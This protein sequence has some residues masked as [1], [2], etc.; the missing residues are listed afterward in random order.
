MGK[1]IGKVFRGVT[2]IFGGG[3]AKKMA[4]A[5][6]RQIEAQRQMQ[7]EAEER[8]EARRK[9][10]EQKALEK[11]AAEY[12]SRVA[13]SQG[14]RGNRLASDERATLNRLGLLG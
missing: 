5:V 6:E 7:R 8:A 10:E 9:E 1:A 14:R 2:S 11:A 3:S 4:A 13:V 12:R